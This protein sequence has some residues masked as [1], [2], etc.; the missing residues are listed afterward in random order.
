VSVRLFHPGTGGEF[1]AAESA[2]VHWL[3]SGWRRKDHDDG[4]A[5]G[6]DGETAM[7]APDSSA[8]PTQE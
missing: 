1:D 8:T 4:S 3:R 6:G 5:A 7:T 2:V